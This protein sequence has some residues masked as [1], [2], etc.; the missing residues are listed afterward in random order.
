MNNVKFRVIFTSLLAALIFLWTQCT[1]MGVDDTNK[2]K[3]R[4]YNNQ[5]QLVN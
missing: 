5:F 4:K 2:I 3:N 1:Y